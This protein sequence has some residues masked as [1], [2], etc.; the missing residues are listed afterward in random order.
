MNSDQV[1]L[2]DFPVF[3][4]MKLQT[5][6]RKSKLHKIFV[7]PESRFRYSIRFSIFINRKNSIKY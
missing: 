7:V 2:L 5:T 3:C 1:E 6:I 4:I